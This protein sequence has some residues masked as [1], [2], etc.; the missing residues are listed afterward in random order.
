MEKTITI[1][2]K[3][4]FYRTVGKGKPV[5]LLHGFGETSSIWD[6]TITHLSDKCRL[7][8]PDLPGSGASELLAE[9]TI[10]GMAEVMFQLLKSEVND[11]KAIIIGHSMGGYITLAL[12]DAHPEV[13]RALGL[14]H[15]TAYADS[16][17]KKTTRRKGIEFIE[18][19]GAYEFLKA[20]IPN[21]FAPGSK[22]RFSNVIDELIEAGNN[23]SPEALVSYYEAMMKRPDRNNV[24][25]T[26]KI[27]ILFILA[28]HDTAVPLQDGLT[29]C[30]LPDLSY[31]HV[32]HQSGH[33][34]ML[35]EANRT[36]RILTDFITE[37]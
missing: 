33:M 6:E 35:E 8:V 1:G 3:K 23:F 4:I 7:I 14:F 21:L 11:E 5:L 10:E 30:H 32:L 31:I 13:F 19:N 2:G 16:E 18:K 9:T 28:K 37:S 26:M 20:S 15:S 22:S 29:L 25:K 24:L 27:P 36:N 17:E 34:G 12:A